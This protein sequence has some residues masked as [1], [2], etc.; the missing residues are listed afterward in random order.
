M[1]MMIARIKPATMVPVTEFSG[2]M[3]ALLL[4]A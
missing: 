4:I 2:F 3:G 1:L